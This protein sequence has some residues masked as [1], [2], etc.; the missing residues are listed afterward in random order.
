MDL[1]IF[2]GPQQGASYDDLLPSPQQP[3]NSASMP[4]SAP[5]TICRWATST[6]SPDPVLAGCDEAGR[7]RASLVLSVGQVLC[8]GQNEEELRRRADAI[9]RDVAELRASGF[10]GTPAEVVDRI[11]TFADVGATRCY[12][13]TL[14]LADLDHLQLVADEIAPQLN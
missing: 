14:D 10:A 4:S 7:E 6:V 2:T 12:L 11:G 5:I 3:R 9:G 1:R 13:Q 8:V